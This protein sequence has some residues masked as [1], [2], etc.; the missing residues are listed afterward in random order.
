MIAGRLSRTAS[1]SAITHPTYVQPRKM[2][3]MTTDARSG[4]GRR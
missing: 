3:T 1:A 2:L 4:A